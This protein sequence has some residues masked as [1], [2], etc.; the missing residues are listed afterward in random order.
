MTYK[1][2]KYIPTKKILAILDS[3]HCTGIDGKDY[4]PVKHELQDILWER[5]NRQ[6]ETL[7]K[8]SEA[9]YGLDPINNP[10]SLT[11]E[12]LQQIDELWH[13]WELEQIPF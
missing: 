6:A 4:E 8:Q 12:Q 9:L 7:L 3:P 2:L 13:Q 5:Q 1:N 11:P 10:Y